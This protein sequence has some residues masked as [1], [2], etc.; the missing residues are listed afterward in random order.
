MYRYNQIGFFVLIVVWFSS[1]FY[2]SSKIKIKEQEY[3]A[4]KELISKY[5]TLKNRYSKQTLEKNKKKIIEFLEIF[6]IS[7]N[8]KKSNRVK[9]DILTFELKKK[10]VNKIISYILNSNVDIYSMKIKKIDKYKISFEV[11]I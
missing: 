7:Y 9:K 2:F 8:I 3:I 1:T 10:N 4:K 11:I 5:D 6:D